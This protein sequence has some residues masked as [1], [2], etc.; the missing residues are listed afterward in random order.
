MQIAHLVLDYMN[1]LL[2]PA[3]AVFG[4]AVFRRA[5]KGKIPSLSEIAAGSFSATF[6]T[7]TE[8]AASM[9]GD[10][11][12]ESPKGITIDQFTRITA[13]GY[14]EA[15]TIGESLREGRPV[16]LDLTE[17]SEADAKRLVDFCA[18][19]AF[20]SFGSM[21]KVTNRLFIVTSSVQYSA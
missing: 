20:L 21:E 11:N 2:W 3:V 14:A 15:R 4:I 12:A 16:L 18:G 19:A 7:S 17:V 13:K 10:E 5:I 8:E 9:A 6:D 1:T